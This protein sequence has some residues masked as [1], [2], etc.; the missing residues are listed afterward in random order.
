MYEGKTGAVEA[1]EI[2]HRDKDGNLIK[3]ILIE[4]GVVKEI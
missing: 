1:L 4:D 2:E 3:K